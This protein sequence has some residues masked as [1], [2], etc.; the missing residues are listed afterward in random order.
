MASVM[1]E[2]SSFWCH[3]CSRLH[4]TSAGEAV[5][6]CPVCAAAPS[7]SLESIVDVVD[8]RT[9]L[10][11]CHPAGRTASALAETLP[12]V[13]VRDAGLTCPICLDVLEPGASAAETPCQHVYHPACLAP[14]LEARGTCPVCR[15]KPVP[16]EDADGSPDG[17]VL[18]DQRNGRSALVR[19][20]AGRLRMVGV[21]DEDGMLMRHCSPLPYRARSLGVLHGLHWIR[22]CAARFSSRAREPRREIV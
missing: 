4:Q 20:T 10:D 8:A 5:A 18:W 15:A 2:V 16:E 12:L 7:A 17:L 13:T 21:L 6:V 14:W 22:H 11:G 9:F 3:T 19:R 1:E